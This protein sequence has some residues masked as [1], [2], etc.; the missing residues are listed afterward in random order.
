MVL[1]SLALALF[2]RPQLPAQ[3]PALAQV[4]PER[5]GADVRF[6]ADNA[7]AGR[8]TPSL[9]LEV[10]AG[11]VIARLERLG[12]EPAGTEGYRQPFPL[13]VRRLDPERTTLAVGGARGERALVFGKDY[14]PE[15]LSHLVEWTA[16][17]PL[18]S[19]GT[20]E[21]LEVTAANPAGRWVVLFDQGG[22]VRPA[23][24]RFAEA[25]AAGVLV[26]PGP[27][28]GQNPYVIRFEPTAQSM[29]AGLTTRASNA[30][31]KGPD[32][33]VVMLPTTTWKELVQL[34]D[35]ELGDLV[36]G[37]PEAGVDLGL[38]VVDQRVPVDPR[39]EASNI[40]A[41]L[42]GR[43]PAKAHEV[44]LLMAH[45]DGRGAPGGEVHNGADDNASGSAALLALAE[46][47]T[48][49]GPLDRT[50]MLL[51]TAGNAKGRLG[52]KA[53][54][55]APTLGKGELV[56]LAIELTTLGLGHPETLRVA[57]GPTRTWNSD[58]VDRFKPHAAG[59]GFPMLPDGD[60]DW[61]RSAARVLARGL[62]VPTVLVSAGAHKVHGT[63]QDVAVP[64]RMDKIARAARAVWGLVVEAAD[65]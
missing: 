19:G 26:T 39:G 32:L 42:T 17:G 60:R 34:T 6:L 51:W 3:E 48:A 1:L 47:L 21:P 20:G 58:W 50:V 22:K 2:P 65:F 35:V 24:Q 63:P 18:V 7:L 16:E 28:Y 13:T 45:Y 38:R 14:Y 57:P 37:V 11:F 43:D 23:L 56:F 55:S 30:Q 41:R 33:P 52:A 40:V 44:V 8:N 10:A 5:I 62:T 54:T 59:E 36:D 46:A 12:L 27:D 29:L 9:G 15:R 31:P 49:N 61:P 4:T 25:G 53:W 64:L